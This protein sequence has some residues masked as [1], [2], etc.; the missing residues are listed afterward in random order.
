MLKN[1]K[2]ANA[3]LII[4]DS[5]EFITDKVEGMSKQF[6]QFWMS[7]FGVSPN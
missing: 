6:G 3:N 1:Q 5:R 2:S 7:L 4:V